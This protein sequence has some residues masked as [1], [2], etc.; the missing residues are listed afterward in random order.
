MSESPWIADWMGL[1]PSSPEA[2]DAPG[3]PMP[4]RVRELTEALRLAAFAFAQY[5]LDTSTPPDEAV[6][7]FVA[8]FVQDAKLRRLAAGEPP[9]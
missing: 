5:A 1:Q 2:S 9:K 4:E 8:G 3:V 6:D 7:D